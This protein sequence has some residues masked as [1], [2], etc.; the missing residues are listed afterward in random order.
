MVGYSIGD[1]LIRFKN[2]AGAKNKTFE[3]PSTKESE[4]VAK[5]LQKLGF[6]NDVKKDK[7]KLSVTLTF[8]DKKPRLVALKLVSKPGLRIYMG[9][10]EIE[11]KKGPSTYLISTPKGIL[12]SKEAIKMRVGGEVI[13][14]IT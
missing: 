10:P 12:S 8:K 4:A 11:S 5:S 6:F 7:N 3:A 9:V 13:A 1:F 14:E 2:A